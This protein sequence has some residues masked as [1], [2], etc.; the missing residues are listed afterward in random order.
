MA[1]AALVTHAHKVAEW[2]WRVFGV[3]PGVDSF[4]AELA[5]MR[6]ARVLR[7]QFPAAGRDRIEAAL[8]VVA[9]S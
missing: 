4:A 2:H 1:E 7:K 8:A 3:R 6:V 5:R 9:G